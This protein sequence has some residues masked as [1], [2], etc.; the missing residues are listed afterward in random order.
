VTVALVLVGYAAVL[1]A[2]APAALR[3]GSWAARAPRLGIAVW[4][5][6]SLSA[7]LAVVLAGV[8]LAVPATQLS[9]DLGQLLRACVMALRAEYAAP[10]GALPAAVGTTAALAVLGRL[11][12]CAAGALLRAG[13]DRR[14]HADALAIVGRPVHRLGAVVV[15][16]HTAA[17]YCLP[18]RA[19]RI[20]LTSAAVAALAEDELSA[21]LAH[22]RAHLRGRHHL[23]LAGAQAFDR[24]FPGVPLFGEAR[25]Q[26]TALVEM[27]AD[28]AAARRHQRRTVA[29]ALLHVAGARA[30]AAGLAAGGPTAVAR[31]RRMLAPARPVS[32]A[33]RILASTAVVATLLL[34][35]AVAAAPAA[36][37]TRL[38]YCPLPAAS[39]SV[40]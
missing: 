9:T 32:P 26:V 17:A 25:R 28:D 19:R 8:A 30:P 23:V 14:E 29:A 27:L 38:D 36:A 18:G 33:A 2:A 11:V 40:P 3:H 10:G 34:P 15:D 13:R 16:H 5:A 31:V 22:E 39:A 12:C 35:V 7:V 1:A 21:V 37:A 20:V 6:L 4:Q 24:A